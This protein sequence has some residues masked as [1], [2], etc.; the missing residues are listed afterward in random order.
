MQNLPAAD[1]EVATCHEDRRPVC[2]PWF[3]ASSCRSQCRRPA[4]TACVAT[5]LPRCF[6]HCPTLTRMSTGCH[7][8]AAASSARAR[9]RRAAAAL[10]HRR[11]DPRGAWCTQVQQPAVCVRRPPRPAKIAGDRADRRGADGAAAW[12][13]RMMRLLLLSVTVATVHC[14]ASEEN[15]NC[16]SRGHC[17]TV[18][19]GTKYPEQVTPHWSSTWHRRV[20]RPSV[21]CR[22]AYAVAYH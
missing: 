15:P 18:G 20:S 12:R 11:A 13:L 14:T 5:G 19:P 2:P 22:C 4:S 16:V 10:Q 1:I 3:P 7:A 6:L 8:A 17:I 21:A 9:P